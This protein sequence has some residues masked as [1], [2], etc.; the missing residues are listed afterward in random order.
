MNEFMIYLVRVSAGMGIVIIPYYFLLRNDTHLEIK[1]FYLLAGIWLSWIAPL[2]TIQSPQILSGAAPA[3]F[4]DPSLP[5]ET[6]VNAIGEGQHSS[7]RFHWLHPVMAVYVTG[8]LYLFIRNLVFLFRWN[9]V[10]KRSEKQKGVA[11]TSTGHVF[12]LFNRIFV[13]E[14]MDRKK[15]LH[16]ILLHEKAHLRQ[17]HFIDHIMVEASLLLTWFNPFTWLISRMIKE[18]HEHLA[19]RQVLS[20]GIPPA[21]YRARLLQYTLGVDLFRPGN[22]FNHS[23]TFKRFQMMK[24]PRKHAPGIVKFLLIIPSVLVTLSLTAGTISEP[25]TV[26]GKVIFAD[27]REPATGA[28]VVIKGST[29][30]TVVDR[31]GNFSLNAG[32]NDELVISFVGYGTLVTKASKVGRKSLQLTPKAFLLEVDSRSGNDPSTST[33][34]YSPM[35][36]EGAVILLDGE[37][38]ESAEDLDTYDIEHIEV[39]KD[40]DHPLAKKYQ[41]ADGLILITSKQNAEN[42]VEKDGELFYIVEEM[43][44]F[45]GGKAA[46]GNFIYSQLAYPESAKEKGH[47]GEVQVGFT[48]NTSGQIRDIHVVQ[49]SDPAFDSAA[50][51]ALRNMPDWN[52]GKQRGKPVSVKVIV[53]VRFEPGRE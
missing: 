26:H 16:T 46:L 21:Q 23:F 49:S 32:K 27:S 14:E 22:S 7:I 13:P 1:R 29:V 9:S 8:L 51:D 36:I 19:D 37:R 31:D 33:G 11:F 5:P 40:P 30:G 15:D 38:I 17:L 50:V 39:I 44:M 53:P 35:P 43:P 4:I 34:N 42:P 28:A 10:W 18:N 20:E 45:P 52:P 25:D 47:E 6:P 48:V 41:A 12:T 3:F 2:I 24:K